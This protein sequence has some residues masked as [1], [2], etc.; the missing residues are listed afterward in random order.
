MLAATDNGYPVLPRSELALDTAELARQLI[1]KVIVRVTAQGVLSGR[2]VE[3]EA[4]PVGDAAS[5]AYRG[6]TARNRALFLCRGHAY[7]Y[8]AYGVSYL[9]NVSSE[10][11]GVGAGVL[12]R[13]LEPLE[14][15]ATMQRNRRVPGF[16]RSGAGTGAAC[17]RP[18]HRSP[19]R[20]RRPLPPRT[21][22]DRARQ[23]RS[24]RSRNE[25]A[26]WPLAGCGPPAAFLHPRGSLRERPQ[27]AQPLNGAQCSAH[28]GRS[29]RQTF[30]STPVRKGSRCFRPEYMPDSAAPAPSWEHQARAA[31]RM[32][33]PEPCWT[34]TAVFSPSLGAGGKG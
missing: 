30:A 24:S 1:G 8:L 23:S 32:T 29:G 13:A 31:A 11:A 33:P 25:H 20:R 6:K 27:G 7:V 17:R 28:G 9:L 12:I 19:P 34:R 22:L 18:R 21:A 3:T 5:H 4:Y 26:H 14:G 16:A 10:T 15:I 2:V